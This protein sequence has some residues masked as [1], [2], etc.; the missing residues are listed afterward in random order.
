MEGGARMIV[1]IF[2]ACSIFLPLALAKLEPKGL[3]V[4]FYENSCPQA[5]Q[6][7]AEVVSEA[8]RK[9]PGVA[10][11]FLRIFFHD[12]FVNG[13]DASILLDSIPSGEKV[14]KDSPANG[15]FLRGLEVIDTAKA[16]LESECPGIVSCADTLSFATRDGSVLAGVPQYNM[17]GGRRDGLVSRAAD[18]VSNVPFVNAPIQQIIELFVRKGLTQEEMVVLTGA[19]SIGVAHC[20]NFA[21]RV[22]KYNDTFQIDPKLNDVDSAKI[23]SACQRQVSNEEIEKT[24]LPFDTQTPFKMDGGFY[25]NLLKGTGL[26]ESDQAMALDPRTRPIVERLAEDEGKWLNQFGRAMSRLAAVD[27]KTG[28][29]GEIRKKC[30]SL[31]LE[32]KGNTGIAQNLGKTNNDEDPGKLDKVEDSGKSDNDVDASTHVNSSDV[33]QSDKKFDS[34]RTF[35]LGIKLA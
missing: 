26:I 15:K 29:E 5:E 20:S 11:G 34:S 2:I 3:H 23:K 7:V 13:C 33:V 28:S 6:I 18:V 30:R 25:T 10:A 1:T 24:T 35:D 27:V 22:N 16:R 14:E 19:H 17:P 9:D 21:Y 31:N 32:N 12:C 8:Y 4:G